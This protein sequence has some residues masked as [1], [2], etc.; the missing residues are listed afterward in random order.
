MDADRSPF[1]KYTDLIGLSVPAFSDGESITN[2]G[3]S[4]AGGEVDRDVLVPLLKPGN[5][6][7]HNNHQPRGRHVQ[8]SW[9]LTNLLY[10]LT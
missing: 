8:C 10:F 1:Q 4:E 6:G 7:Y 2:G 5:G 3:V 9:T